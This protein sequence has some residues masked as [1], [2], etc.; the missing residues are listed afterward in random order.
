MQSWNEKELGYHQGENDYWVAVRGEVYDLTDFWQAQHSDIQGLTVTG[1]QMLQLGGQDLSVNVLTGDFILLTSSI[2]RHTFRRPSTLHA[3]T[4]ST[5]IHLSSCGRT[6]TLLSQEQSMSLELSKMTPVPISVRLSPIQ[7]TGQCSLNRRRQRQLAMGHLLP[8][9]EAV[10]Q[11]H[12]R[13]HARKSGKRGRRG[14][15]RHGHI[16]DLGHL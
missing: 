4:W 9:H 13:L 8:V 1:D 3:R 15:C 7:R 10:S 6:S 16:K 14:R 11:G 5:I 12:L 2:D